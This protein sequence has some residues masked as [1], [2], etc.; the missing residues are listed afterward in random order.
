MSDAVYFNGQR[1]AR[2]EARFAS[3]DRGVL[4]GFGFFET[5]RT[6]GG[7]PHHWRYHQRRLAAACAT[8]GIALPATFLARDEPRLRETVR[9]MLREAGVADAVFRYT[10]TAGPANGGPAEMM[11]LRP[12]PPSAPKEGI[13]LWVLALSR[14]N[15]EWLP[16]PK[17]LNYANALLG[18]QELARRTTEPHDEGLFLSRDGGWVVESARQNIAW[19][20][21]GVLC[22][23]EP[24]LGA[25]AG[26]ALAWVLEQA[27]RAEH[28]R[29]RVDELLTAE[30]VFVLNAVRGITPVNTIR[31][32][33]GKALV[34]SLSSHCHPLV[35]A[36]RERWNEALD[37]TARG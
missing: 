23:P 22:Y 32:V 16:R 28:R 15:G 21:D 36:L 8:A 5:F 37:V 9:A 14:D 10:V 19:V 31:D 27:F 6:S 26:T 29:A 34:A 17:S 12:L 30:A 13:T 18:A 4:Y 25:V 35:V 3:D 11:S 2:T 24:A 20:R 7:R 1:S 33:E